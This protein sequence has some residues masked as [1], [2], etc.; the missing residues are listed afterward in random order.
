MSRVGAPRQD[1]IPIGEIAEPPFARLPDPTTL[2]QARAGRFRNLSEGHPLAAYL[3]FLAALSDAQHQLQDGLAVPDLPAPDVR[4][5]AKEFGMPPLDRGAFSADA[6]FETTLQRLFS[7]AREIDMPEPARAALARATGADMA[8]RGGM[9]R[10]VL[11]DAVPVEGLADHLFIVAALHVHFARQASRLEA[12]TLVPVGEG[13]CPACGG[14]PVAS[15]VVGWTGALNTRFCA[16]SLCN[17]LWNA[18]RIKCM[19]CGSLTGINY[20]QVAGGDTQVQ[21]ETCNSCHGYV[22]ILQQV[23]NPALDPV[24]DDVASLALDVLL[25]ERG[26]RR[27][28]VNPF[29]LGY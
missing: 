26:Y 21:A 3:R 6:T 11:A 15:M 19:L 5:R 8:T 7:L 9:L 22:K 12:K 28:A 2:F 14:P 10:A 1:P 23:Q 17:T 27:G 18:L 20:Q 16:C 4:A 13:A 25:R 29:L 24:A